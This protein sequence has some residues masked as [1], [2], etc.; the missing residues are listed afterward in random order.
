MQKWFILVT[1]CSLFMAGT[2]SRADLLEPPGPHRKILPP[3]DADLPQEV[4]L[5]GKLSWEL[6]KLP[7][8]TEKK[9]RLLLTEDNGEIVALGM[10]GQIKA[11][12]PNETIDP[13]KYIGKRVKVTVLARWSHPGTPVISVE[14]IISIKEAKKPAGS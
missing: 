7:D 12:K 9:G 4:A 14:K 11:A 6:Q 10:A 13:D 5:N 8:G 1:I 2:V 3:P